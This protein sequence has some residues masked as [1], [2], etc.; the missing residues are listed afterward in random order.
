M[1]R[2]R[3]RYRPPMRAPSVWQPAPGDVKMGGPSALTPHPGSEVLEPPAI[4]ILAL[5]DTGLDP[6]RLGHQ[7]AS[8]NLVGQSLANLWLLRERARERIHRGDQSLA[9]LCVRVR[10]LAPLPRPHGTVVCATRDHAGFHRAVH[11]RGHLTTKFAFVK[12]ATQPFRP[13]HDIAQPI[14]LSVPPV[15]KIADQSAL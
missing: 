11:G 14:F 5:P 12:I 10:R 13:R 4:I 3:H 1:F 15:A 2:W 9:R 8:R 6:S 7:H